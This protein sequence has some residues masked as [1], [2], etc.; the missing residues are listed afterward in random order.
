[1]LIGK[2]IV[3]DFTS[4]FRGQLVDG[5]RAGK[6]MMNFWVAG[7]SRGELRLCWKAAGENDGS[8]SSENVERASLVRPRT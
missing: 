8:G 1:M 4:R 6:A 2:N 7:S 5:N 3:E